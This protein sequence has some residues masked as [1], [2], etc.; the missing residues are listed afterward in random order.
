MFSTS[1]LFIRLYT[2]IYYGFT[3]IITEICI[4]NKGRRFTYKEG[5]ISKYDLLDKKSN[6]APGH[7]KKCWKNYVRTDSVILSLS[8]I[9]NLTSYSNRM[10]VYLVFTAEQKPDVTHVTLKTVKIQVTVYV[11]N[12]F[13]KFSETLFTNFW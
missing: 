13:K 7:S 10:L 5:T 3:W 9:L 2:L 6:H 4:S 1:Q 12:A 8:T 11:L